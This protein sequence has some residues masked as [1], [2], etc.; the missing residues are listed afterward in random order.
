MSTP[1][2]ERPA[3][4]PEPAARDGFGQVLRG[5]WTKFRSVRSTV[6]CLILA[7]GLMVG[8]SMLGATTSTTSAGGDIPKY[9]DMF[10][11]TYRPLTG[12]GSIVAHVANQ[13][14]TGPSAKAGIMIKQGSA[15]P[16]SPGVLPG[17]PY[18]AISVS[19][20]HGV[21]LEADFNSIRQGSTGP[22]PRWLKL[23]R[24]GTTVYGYESADGQTW[25]LIGQLT[26]A[27]LPRKAEAG[28]FVTS[29]STHLR[30]IRHGG[31]STSG[32]DY[33][34]GVATFD[35]VRL[36]PAK[37]AP[38]ARWADAD[39]GGSLRNM[40]GT[41][42]RGGSTQAGGTF[43]VTGAGDVRP[44]SE[45]EFGG[46]N[47]MVRD[48]LAGVLFGLMAIVALGVVFMTSEYKTSILRTTFA[49]SPRRGR[50]LAAKAIVLGTVTLAA[51]LVASVA[52]FFLV[53]PIQR[54]RGFEP[55][56]YPHPSLAD[57]PVLRAVVGTALFLTVLALFSL[58]VGAL[59]RRSARAISLVIALVIL[60]AITAPFL[61]LGAAN[62]LQRLTPVAGLAI[63]QT[64]HRYDTAIAPWAGFAVLCA[65]TAVAL[66]VAAWLLRRR[67]A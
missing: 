21:R 45:T 63:Q 61:P 57:E 46:D 64:R 13:R 55:P 30:V 47:D 16:G 24:A 23:T 60:P 6:W 1:T 48:G 29:P 8:L 28:L 12:D 20:G 14:N 11:F 67:D 3:D 4:R 31:S 56:A 44:I 52:A 36:T 15:K 7:I 32:P 2:I 27:D 51:G 25:R 50:V 18:A 9:Q 65:Y 62:W 34:A 49:A 41:Q 26:V 43:T 59:L 39:V 17:A 10:H 35:N 40:D 53:Q 42:V 22:A 5:E 33:T 54:D 66:G 38:T 19:P 58:G 37:A